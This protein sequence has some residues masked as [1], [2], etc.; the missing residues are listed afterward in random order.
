[1]SSDS[2]QAQSERVWRA[3]RFGLA[4]QD[5]QYLVYRIGASLLAG[6]DGKLQDFRPRCVASLKF[7]TRTCFTWKSSAAKAL[8]SSSPTSLWASQISASSRRESRLLGDE[9]KRC[10]QQLVALVGQQLGRALAAAQERGVTIRTYSV[11]SCVWIDQNGEAL[12][13]AGPLVEAAAG[14]VGSWKVI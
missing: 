2:D 7:S 12:V 11:R 5:R 3:K 9:G 13:G 1:M 10:C 14:A 4:D 8:T 6:P